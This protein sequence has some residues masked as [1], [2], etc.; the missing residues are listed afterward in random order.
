M[1]RREGCLGLVWMIGCQPVEVTKQEV[2][3]GAK[4]EA[5]KPVIQLPVPIP[6][7]VVVMPAT[8]PCEPEV[9]DV[10]TT[11]FKDRVLVRLPIGVEVNEAPLAAGSPWARSG[12]AEMVSACGATVR[13]VA[14]GLVPAA[15]DV[16]LAGVRDEVLARVHALAPGAIQ[17]QDV[18]TDERGLDGTYTIAGEGGPLRGWFV[19]KRK[20]GQLVWA[21]YEASPEAFEALVPTFRMSST[22]LLVLPGT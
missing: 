6:A 14:I 18:R 17:W 5:E 22:R 12:A 8:P 2:T 13:Q 20:H 16:A 19:L 3:H 7:P 21:L 1:L 10:P 9:A 15:E 11:L 4:Q